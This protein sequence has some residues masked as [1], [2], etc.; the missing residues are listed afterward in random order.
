[1]RSL[2][3]RFS[4]RHFNWSFPPE[5]WDLSDEEIHVWVA[6]L[7]QPEA[8]Y[9]K[10]ARTLSPDEQMRASR[11]QFRQHRMNFTIARGL[12]RKILSGYAKI[13][14][15]EL[16]F[17]YGQNGKPRLTSTFGSSDLQFNLS[18]G[19]GLALYAVSRESR[20]GN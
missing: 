19:G 10:L 14:A 3:E 17:S 8:D 7:D 12:L 15:S 6:G 20:T 1:M 16:Q 11:F 5:H 2:A 18:H 13:P 4:T 9:K